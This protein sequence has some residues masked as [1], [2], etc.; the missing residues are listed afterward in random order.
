MSPEEEGEAENAVEEAIAAVAQNWSDDL[1]EGFCHRN[2]DPERIHLLHSLT[3]G[4]GSGLIV[5]P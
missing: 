5:F 4:H 1:S 2:F 3:R